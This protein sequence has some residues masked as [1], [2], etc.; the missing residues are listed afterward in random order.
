MAYLMPLTLI[1]RIDL[2]D[3]EAE[4]F[5]LG[6]TSLFPT[7][8]RGVFR[9]SSG[10]RTRVEVGVDST[11]ASEGEY[12][13]R[14][15]TRGIRAPC[16]RFRATR[17]KPGGRSAPCGHEQATLVI[18]PR[19][20]IKALSSGRSLNRSGTIPQALGKIWTESVPLK[21]GMWSQFGGGAT[22]LLEPSLPIVT[23]PLP[24]SGDP[25]GPNNRSRGQT[26]DDHRRVGPIRRTCLG[27]L[28]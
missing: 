15:S 16:Q 9:V 1:F 14:T 28:T 26:S 4:L 21:A 5:G 19:N 7:G 27:V 8:E 25:G 13:T 24:S 20:E 18:P 11:D 10:P 12:E 23:F 17:T 6:A 22:S 3:S 2:T